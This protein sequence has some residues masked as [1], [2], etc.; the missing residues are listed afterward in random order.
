LTDGLKEYSTALL[1]HFG[2]WRQPERRQEKGP[3]PKPRWMPQPGL[4]YAQVVKAYRRRRLVAVK[5]RAVFGTLEAIEQ[6]L[7]ACG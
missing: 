2:Q 3:M 1:T 7:R 4:L 6:V 5:P